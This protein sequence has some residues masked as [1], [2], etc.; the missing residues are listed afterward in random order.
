M[1]PAL[2]SILFSH[3]W[4]SLLQ[5]RHQHKAKQLFC[6]SFCSS[7]CLM[8]LCI[9]T[10]VLVAIFYLYFKNFRLKKKNLYSVVSPIQENSIPFQ[11]NYD[12]VVEI[13]CIIKLTWTNIYLLIAC[14]LYFRFISNCHSYHL[15]LLPVSFTP[16]SVLV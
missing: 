11:F 14:K 7:Q 8:K 1:E 16:A 15:I 10:S 6:Y 4:M 3:Q 2:F 5:I 9:C 13:I 12:T